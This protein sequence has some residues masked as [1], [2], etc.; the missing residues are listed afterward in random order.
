MTKNKKSESRYNDAEYQLRKLIK[1]KDGSS[2]RLKNCIRPWQEKNEKTEITNIR[3]EKLGITMYRRHNNR[4][5]IIIIAL[6]LHKFKL[7][8]NRE[9]LNLTPGK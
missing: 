1:S 5:R 7:R 9:N 6:N 4:I 2:K 8:N 3:N